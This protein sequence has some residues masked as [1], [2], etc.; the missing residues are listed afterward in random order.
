MPLRD[1]QP[2]FP[3]RDAVQERAPRTR[4]INNTDRIRFMWMALGREVKISF[5]IR[6]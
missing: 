2:Q 6:K 3:L 1:G 5:F 4:R